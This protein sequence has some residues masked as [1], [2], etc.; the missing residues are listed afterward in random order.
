MKKK[1]S[2]SKPAFFKQKKEN[3]KKRRYFFSMSINNSTN[4][5]TTNYLSRFFKHTTT[6]EW[7]QKFQNRCGYNSW[8]WP[9]LSNFQ[10]SAD[11]IIQLEKS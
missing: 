4:Q 3:K 7:L 10:M 6:L 2:K 11:F 9:E 5:F 8:V 1:I